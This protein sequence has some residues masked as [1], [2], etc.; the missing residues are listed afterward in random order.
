MFNQKNNF[1]WFKINGSMRQIIIR[2]SAFFDF[3]K[4]LKSQKDFKFKIIGTD[5]DPKA[6]GKVL[7]DKFYNSNSINSE[8]KFFNYF[9]INLHFLVQF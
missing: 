8:I 9:N 4:C 1:F 3:L 7:V 5:N 2:G 6:Y